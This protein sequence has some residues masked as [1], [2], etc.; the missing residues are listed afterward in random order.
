MSSH[1]SGYEAPPEQHDWAAPPAPLRY[2]VAADG[3]PHESSVTHA[4]GQWTDYSSA[5]PG[6]SR[7]MYEAYPQH[8]GYG[9]GAS[10]P[11][12]PPAFPQPPSYAPPYPIVSTSTTAVGQSQWTAFA[13]PGSARQ[14]TSVHARA[15]GPPGPS[16]SVNASKLHA[17]DGT[18]GKKKTRQ[19][20]SACRA[21]RSRRVRCD[22][23]DKQQQWEW[24]YGE[25][26][27]GKQPSAP[28]LSGVQNR[29]RDKLACTNCTERK[30]VCM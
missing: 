28:I 11:Q 9:G 19:Q 23:N 2:P 7:P 26:A 5:V 17:L 18:T 8:P 16:S 27:S 4:N 24:L 12:N 6:P 29:S 21:C 13:P 20:F 22:L 3:Q 30:Q 1:L 15:P 25:E 10:L 14:P